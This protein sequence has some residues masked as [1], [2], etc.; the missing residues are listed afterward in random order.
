MDHSGDGAIFGGL[1]A[2]NAVIGVLA[3]MVEKIDARARKN[4]R[5]RNQHSR[6]QE[7]AEDDFESAI[8]PRLGSER[9]RLS[10]WRWSGE[11]QILPH[12]PL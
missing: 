10:H 2:K 12:S 11:H 7:V 4:D 3:G 5:C 6:A 1:A 9:I 8:S